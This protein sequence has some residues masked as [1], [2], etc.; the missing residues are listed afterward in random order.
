MDAR[1]LKS[2]NALT[3]AGIELLSLNPS[4]SLKEI[5]AYAGVGRATLYRHFE[6]REQLIHE[7][8]VETL[9][10]MG[11]LLKPSYDSAATAV[12]AIKRTFCALLPLG[13]RYHFLLLLWDVIEQSDEAMQVY[14]SQLSSL[15]TLIEQAKKEGTVNPELSTDWVVSLIDSMLYI[16]W[17]S[18]AKGQ[19]T[20]EEV[21]EQALHS[22]M[23]GIAR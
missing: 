21:I 19:M 23:H 1:A 11:E 15:H 14:N 5:A 6:S 20:A 18:I 13:N 2:R 4:A 8:A 22:L 12:E 3:E 10:M 17:T 7:I 16:G 9:C